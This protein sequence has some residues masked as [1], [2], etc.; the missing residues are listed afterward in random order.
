[1][2]GAELLV[3]KKLSHVPVYGIAALTVSRARFRGLA[4]VPVPSA[5]D[6]PL[7]ATLLGGWRPG[8]GWELSARA[9][10]ASGAPTTPWVAD[11][12]LG[13]VPDG[14]R[15]NAGPRRPPF[16]QLD[17]RAD[18]RFRLRGGRQLVAYVDVIDVTGRR[19]VYADAWSLPDRRPIPVT[20]LGVL[21]SV[22]LN[23]VF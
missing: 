1:V 14:T 4:G 11:N 9:R 7:A 13:G 10:A 22:G 3:Q 20:T 23:W 21:P 17:A 2:T 18:R 12:A 16:Y 8:A 19:N 15:H 5:F 6:V